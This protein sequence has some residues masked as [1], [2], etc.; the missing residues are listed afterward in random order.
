MV[1]R[2]AIKDSQQTKR[3]L[4]A[5]QSRLSDRA[6]VRL[7][8][9]AALIGRR[10]LSPEACGEDFYARVLQVIESLDPQRRSKLRE[11]VDWVEAYERT[12]V[13]RPRR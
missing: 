9:A 13:H 3:P 10:G 11:C 7:H 6:K 5:P 4:A 8:I 12:D 2:M 1:L